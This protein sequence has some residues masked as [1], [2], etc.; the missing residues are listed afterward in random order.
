MNTGRATA[1]RSGASDEYANPLLHHLG[2]PFLQAARGWTICDRYLSSIMGPRFP[3]RFYSHCAQTDRITN[4]FELSALPTIWD[5]LAERRVSAGYYFSDVPFLAFWGTK[6]RS[7]S[8]RISTFFEDCRSGKLPAVSYVE[9]RFLEE[10]TGLSN[11]DHP[12][13]DLRN[14]RVPYPSTMRGERKA[15]AIP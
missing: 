10:S 15:R 4:S 7:I 5:R 14:G 6:Y 12:H 9:P 13:A 1:L 3:N 8:H 11:D 2:P